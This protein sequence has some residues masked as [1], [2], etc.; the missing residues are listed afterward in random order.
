MNKN[1]IKK[2]NISND[3]KEA[4]STNISSLTQLYLIYAR[5]ILYSNFLIILKNLKFLIHAQNLEEKN[6]IFVL[7]FLNLSNFILKNAFSPNFILKNLVKYSGIFLF[8]VVKNVFL[9]IIFLLHTMRWFYCLGS[10]I[11]SKIP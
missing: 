7:K 9:P 5:K 11:N 6:G 1:V 10:K 2:S 4:T 8:D 3:I